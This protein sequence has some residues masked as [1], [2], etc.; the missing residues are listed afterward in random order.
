MADRFAATCF[1]TA[2]ET[3]PGETIGNLFNAPAAPTSRLG[4][5]Y[6]ALSAGGTMA[7]VVCHYV[8]QRTTALGTEASGVVPENLDNGAVQ[9]GADAGQDHSAEP[10]YTAATEFWEND[11]HLRA[12]AQIQLQPDGHILVAGTQ[13]NGV[14]VTVFS[15]SYTGIAYETIHFVE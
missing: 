10:T 6:I 5:Y 1:Q 7:D 15:A 2:V 14:G 11:V 12:L 4:I 8:I 13:N 3:T 9:G